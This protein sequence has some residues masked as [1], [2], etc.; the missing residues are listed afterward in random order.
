M[1]VARLAVF[2]AAVVPSRRLPLCHL[3]ARVSGRT[4]LIFRAPDKCNT[5]LPTTID[6]QHD[7]SSQLVTHAACAQSVMPTSSRAKIDRRQ[8]MC[9][10]AAASSAAA[11]AR[12]LSAAQSELPAV[13]ALLP[14]RHHIP[15]YHEPLL[16]HPKFYRA[17]RCHTPSSDPGEALGQELLSWYANVADTRGMPWRQKWISPDEEQFVATTEG[18]AKLRELLERRAYEVWISEISKST[19]GKR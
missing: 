19:T 14:K 13:A 16:L 8:T 11:S 12:G 2:P 18:Q 4:V 17:S 7:R 1:S 9:A 10:R 6:A 15:Y 3:R 5:A